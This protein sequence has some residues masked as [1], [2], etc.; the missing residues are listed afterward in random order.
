MSTRISKQEVITV[1]AARQY[2][3]VLC[4]LTLFSN[5]YY[6]SRSSLQSRQHTTVSCCLV[7]FCQSDLFSSKVVWGRIFDQFKAEN[8]YNTYIVMFS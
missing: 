4:S 7:S 2:A 5:I 8:I 1:A 3:V 6:I